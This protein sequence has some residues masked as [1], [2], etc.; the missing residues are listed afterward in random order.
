MNRHNYRDRHQRNRHH[1]LSRS[2]SRLI[3][4]AFV[5]SS[6]FNRQAARG[7]GLLRI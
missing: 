5:S 4:T 7:P 1:A 3:E 2:A 6:S